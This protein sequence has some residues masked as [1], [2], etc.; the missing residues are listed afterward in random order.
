VRFR[1]VVR[2]LG[3]RVV[4]Y[5][6]V[7]DERDLTARIALSLEPG[8]AKAVGV[9]IGNV[10]ASVAVDVVDRHDAAAE[11]VSPVA[12]KCFGMVGPG[13]LLAAGG[14]L[15][16]PAVRDSR[17]PCVHRVDDADADSMGDRIT[18][19]RY[20]MNRPGLVGSPGLGLAYRNLPSA[21]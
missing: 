14:R 6:H 17:C 11:N 1:E 18:C 19:L 5:Y 2:C 21:P 16:P 4:V 9:Q 15:L 12:G 10:V 8:E 3:I 13:G 7:A 20:V